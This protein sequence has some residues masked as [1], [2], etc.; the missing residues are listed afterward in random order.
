MSRFNPVEYSIDELDE[1]EVMNVIIA[2]EE[3]GMINLADK[4]REQDD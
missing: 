1:I 3:C 4:I 2:L